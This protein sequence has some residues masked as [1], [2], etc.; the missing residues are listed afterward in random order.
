M[1]KFERLGSKV[2]NEEDQHRLNDQRHGD[3]ANMQW[4]T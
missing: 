1:R 2:G 3:Q 4:I